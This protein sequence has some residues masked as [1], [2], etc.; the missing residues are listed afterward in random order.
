MYS[1]KP[2]SS[3]EQS[4]LHLF[5]TYPTSE[6]EGFQSVLDKS[7]V[8]MAN[9]RPTAVLVYKSSGSKP[10]K[11]PIEN[12]TCIAELSDGQPVVIPN[13]WARLQAIDTGIQNPL[14]NYHAMIES[15]IIDKKFTEE[16]RAL[17]QASDHIRAQLLMKQLLGVQRDTLQK[18]FMEYKG[19]GAGDA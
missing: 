7:W 17:E 14:S 15:G 12:F 16:F 13:P 8:S 10:P 2:A 6:R 3:I 18:Y 11:G 5:N 4:C 19:L 9:Q 1:N